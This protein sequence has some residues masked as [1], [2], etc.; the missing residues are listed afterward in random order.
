[1][2]INF[3]FSRIF[4]S[5]YVVVSCIFY[6]CD[7]PL[8]D[9]YKSWSKYLGDNSVSHYSSL[10]QIDT[11]NVHQ[12]KVAW[13]YHSGDA[14]SGSNSKIEC[15]P[16]IIDGVLYGSS[17]RLKLFALDAATGKQKWIFDP[18]A[19]TT[20]AKVRINVNRGVTYWENG[21][22]RRLFF[23]AGPF[24]YAVDPA[25]GKLIDSFGNHGQIDLHDGL[26]REVKDLFITATS[27][28]VIYKNLLIMGMRVQERG[29][30]PPG[31]I[32]AYDVR[33]GSIK[34]IFHT[35]PH[36]GE[37]GYETWED[38]DAWKYIGAANNWAGMSLD[39][40]RGVVYISTGSA[41]FDFYGGLRKGQNLF[42]N[43]VLALNA[44]TG[45]YVWHFQTIHHD[46]WDR[47][48][49][50]P[51]NL[52]T[53]N[54]NGKKID[55]VAQITKLGFVF[56][57]DRDNGKPL[58]PVDE[59]PVPD[60]S[61]LTGEKPWPT[62]PIPRVPKSFAFHSFTE[63]DVNPFVPDSSQAFIK[64]R[65]REIESGN[66]FLPP[67]EKGILIF[68]G[69]D[70]GGEW[71]GAGYDPKTGFLYVNANHSPWI[72]TMMKKDSGNI[73]SHETVADRGERVYV[74]N[75]MSCHGKSREG[76]GAYPE[77]RNIT[78]KYTAHQI[79]DIINNGRGMMPSFGQ[80]LPNDKKALLVFLVN[81]QKEGSQAFIDS[82]MKKDVVQNSSKVPFVPYIP[83]YQKFRSHDGYPANK[84][85][86]GTLTA[87]NLNT[88]ETIW[89]IP[90]GE[91]PE[92]KKKGIPVTG[93]ENY[94]GPVVTS[95][96]LIF[97]AATLDQKIRAFN[98]RT[99]K[100]L[101]EA[102][103]PFAGF[104]TPSTYEVNGKQ[105]VVIACGGGGG[106]LNV[107][108]GDSYIAFALP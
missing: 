43:C 106:R 79:L 11:S 53:I 46:M 83:V 87:I 63:A 38:K 62:Q 1:M 56:I 41:S 34:W 90:L 69:L 100:L 13:E 108:S 33:T 7:S 61:T 84:P 58:F 15:N 78:N 20:K 80:I 14:D 91:Y 94:G 102:D 99:G 95:G 59:V 19:D 93:T 31:H 18:F 36:P 16:I 22:D 68:P 97:I 73:P 35:I 70:G 67:S 98:K 76:N 30:V 89:T 55:A 92:L 24:L 32:R 101:W 26:G 74:N 105:Y 57:L 12:L 10:Q 72:L 51:P 39:Q 44:G 17:P 71:G 28:G 103:L 60:S 6:A 5:V 9:N 88:A 65:L 45:K 23:A 40:K 2:S 25:T 75:C 50:A 81:D 96:G 3:K 27:P 54:R 82:S 52:V 107:P 21:K 42:A 29:D 64:R 66:I 48:P 85:P 8:E 77:L 86:W 4:L 47:D 49:P 37:F 104:A